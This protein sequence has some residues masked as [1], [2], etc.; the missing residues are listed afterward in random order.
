VFH[1]CACAIFFRLH[2]VFHLIPSRWHTR[3]C[4][5]ELIKSNNGR[6]QALKH[7][8]VAFVDVGTAVRAKN[9]QTENSSPSQPGIPTPGIL[10]L[11][12]TFA[13]FAVA[14]A[15]PDFGPQR[16]GERGT[17][18][19]FHSHS[20]AICVENDLLEFMAIVKVAS[21]TLH[22]LWY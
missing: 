2:A 16:S 17:S 6:G 19:H 10:S 3:H 5:L 1:L 12:R 7:R 21:I 8:H 4:V 15:A 13:H 14:A 22:S 11:P 20:K 9:R 18:T